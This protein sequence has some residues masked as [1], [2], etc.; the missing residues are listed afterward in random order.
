[1][2][3]LSQHKPPF[4]PSLLGEPPCLVKYVTLKLSKKY[5]YEVNHRH[6]KSKS[7][8]IIS[9]RG[10]AP[11][12]VHF[13][14]SGVRR[15]QLLAFNSCSSNNDPFGRPRKAQISLV[16]P[17]NSV[18]TNEESKKS[19]W[20]CFRSSIHVLLPLSSSKLMPAFWATSV[21]RKSFLSRVNRILILR[22]NRTTR[23]IIN[24]TMCSAAN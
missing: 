5:S 15:R 20:V 21:G 17:T 13:T 14:F 7:Q 1:M 18:Q 24:I 22:E 4:H 10:R 3:S 8:S 23:I 9:L 6:Y 2:S 16:C 19:S 12:W 11:T